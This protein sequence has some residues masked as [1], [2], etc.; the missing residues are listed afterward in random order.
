MIERT[1][2]IAVVGAGSAGA[3]VA[4]ML[5]EAGRTV[6]LVDRRPHDR[7]GARWV[8]GVPG[9]A[10]DRAGMDAPLPP[11][12][13]GAPGGAHGF[14]ITVP[15]AEARVRV[16]DSPVIDVDMR[17]LVGRLQTR[18]ARA[19]VLSVVGRV[20]AVELADGRPI[21]VE[22]RPPAGGHGH[23][24]RARLFID[25]SGLAGVLRGAVPA[26][27]AACPPP[28]RADICTAAQ[29]QHRVTDPDAGRRFMASHGARPGESLA[30]TGVAGGY[31]VI[32]LFTSPNMDEVGVLTGT[33][34]ALGLPSGTHLMH[35]FLAEQPWIGEA[36]YGGQGAIPIRRAYTVLTAP[37]V[38]LLGD[39]AC[40]VYGAHGSGVGM[41]LV[42]ARILADAVS[43]CVDPG[44][45]GRLHRR[46]A[47]RFHRAYGGLL[48]GAE[49]FRRFSQSLRQD[50]VAALLASGLLSADVVSAS[51]A[52]RPPRPTAG[53]ARQ[54]VRGFLRVPRLGAR[55][56]PV[57]GRVA[58]LH[59]LYRL[60]PE[61][62]DAAALS[63]FDAAV[64]RLAR[65]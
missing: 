35:R 36:L 31:S 5:A 28:D 26:L 27:A 56:A 29:H 18:G 52:Q 8:N 12:R 38:A 6:V 64:R 63:R 49:A 3:A 55:L 42:A 20:D 9:W 15:G 46:Y 7:A 14:V 58:A 34:P 23:R 16:T 39:A 25:A 1:V 45:G 10:F 33:I 57:I 50:E 19:G 54:A 51:L 40:Q 61:R 59:H 48:A 32:T 60:Y 24:I 62:P 41:G 2:D 43:A 13:L 4:A 17:R 44:D 37:G 11:E 22:V 53:A 65:G 47:A 21:A 30:L